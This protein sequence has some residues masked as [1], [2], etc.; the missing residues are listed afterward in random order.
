MKLH[1][2][3]IAGGFLTTTVTS[4]GNGF[5]NPI[6]KK[7]R[8]NMKDHESMGNSEVTFS[9]WDISRYQCYSAQPPRWNMVESQPPRM[10]EEHG[11]NMERKRRFT[12]EMIWRWWP[13]SA[14]ASSYIFT[15]FSTSSILWLVGSTSLG[16]FS[17]LG[18][19]PKMVEHKT[20]IK[21]N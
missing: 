12:P 4:K 11:L 6:R 14:R 2:I 18:I 1:E 9:N 3:T 20:V 21:H 10:A 5:E 8:S 17:A 13:L 19:I 16:P 7:E 15:F